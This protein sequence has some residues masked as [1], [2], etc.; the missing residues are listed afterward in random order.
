MKRALVLVLVSLEWAGFARPQS[1]L[2][3]VID[4]LRSEA[5]PGEAMD[6]MYRV[7]STDRW[8]TFPKFQETAE[9]LKAAMS[10]AGLHHVEVVSPPADGVTQYGFWTMPMAWDVKDAT[11]EIVEP[12]VAAQE[13]VLAD[14]RKIPASLGMWSGPT[15]AEGITAEVAELR[16]LDSAEIGRANL[17]GKFVMVR[18]STYTN[19]LPLIKKGAIG[20]INAHTESPDLRDAHW[21]VN[22]WGDSG[23]GFTQKSTP[24]PCFSIT[25]RQADMISDLLARNVTVRVRAKVASRYYAGTYPYTTAV[26]KG[27]GSDEEVLELGHTTEIGANDNATGVAVMMEAIFSLN[28]LIEAGKLPRP[29]RSI[30]ILAMPELYGSMHYVAANSERIR[31]TVAAI[32]VDTP[33]GPYSLAGTEYTFVLNPDVAR[34]YTD[35]LILRIAERYFSGPAAPRKFHWSPY[36][37]G[38]DTY[39]SD[40]T[41]GIPTVWPYGGSGI[42]VHH[43]SEDTPDKVDSRS[44]RDGAIVTAAYLYLIASAGEAEIP[45][46]A[47]ITATRGYENILRATG[48]ALERMALPR[49]ATALA[50][51][52]HEGLE[53]IAYEADREEQAILSTLRLAPPG[54]REA[55]RAS[56]SPFI[57]S[58]R[59]FAGEQSERPSQ[60]ANRQAAELGVAGPVKPIAPSDRQIEEAAGLVVTRKRF[61]G[62]PL[63]DLPTD[64]WEGWP[65]GAWDATVITALNWCDGRRS[66]A[67]VIRLTRMERDAAGF[68][69]VGYFR[70]L[71]KHGYVEL[72]KK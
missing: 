25:P 17:K 41:I 11:L 18:Q 35:A 13:R 45:R 26:L 71:A 67:E 6:Y 44:V 15:P 55:L 39:Y 66:L 19:K 37:T 69:F 4:E 72:A 54:N 33:T 53:R 24:L 60:A 51:A 21:W 46:L 38:T 31:R 30:R 63:D 70:F 62:I 47:E 48:L 27:H 36:M 49:D 23:W 65:S 32:C 42:P 56:L 58:V 43:N 10:A 16:T 9:Y 12:A 5:R 57:Q 20:V 61:G 68:D 8:F 2:E 52:L 50:H 14:Y 3:K 59:R 1:Q 40:P 34:S 28:R 29:R 64:Q 7:Y 22:Y